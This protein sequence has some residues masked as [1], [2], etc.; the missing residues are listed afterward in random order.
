MSEMR[1]VQAWAGPLDGRWLEVDKDFFVFYF[2]IEMDKSLVDD[3]DA[4]ASMLLTKRYVYRYN[5]LTDRL[6]FRGTQ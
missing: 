6:E 4:D 5:A 1:K 2:P 3:P